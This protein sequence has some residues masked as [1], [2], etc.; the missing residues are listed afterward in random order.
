MLTLPQQARET[1]R[2]TSV[3]TAETTT[4]FVFVAPGASQVA[5]TGDFVNWDPDGIPLASPSR[6]GVWV[7]ELRLSPGLYHYVF[8]L[9]GTEWRPDPNATSQVDDGFGRQN[10]LLLVP[11]P[12]RS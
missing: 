12:Q 5:V 3:A 9:D 2:D 7:A 11:S 4:R 1:V 6:D 10:S 8:V